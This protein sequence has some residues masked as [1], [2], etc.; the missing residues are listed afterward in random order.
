MNS[1]ETELKKPFQYET[2]SMSVIEIESLF[3]PLC[4]SGSNSEPQVT[5][6][7]SRTFEY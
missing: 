6:S 3:E 2:P 5:D 4:G 1:M 7:S